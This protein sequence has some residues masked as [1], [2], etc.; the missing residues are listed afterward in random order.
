MSVFLVLSFVLCGCGPYIDYD[1]YGLGGADIALNLPFPSGQYWIMTQ[2]YKTGSH[3]DY[4]FQWGNDSFALDFAQSGC[5]AYGEPVTPVADGQVIDVKYEGNGDSGYGNTVLVRHEG[6]YVSRYAH[7]S[8]VYVEPGQ[9]LSNYDY[10]GAVGDTGYVS[11]SSCA[12]HPGTHLHLA[13]YENTEPRIPEPM[14]GVMPMETGCWYNREGKENCSGDPGDYEPLSYIDDEGNMTLDMLELRPSWGTASQTE[15]VWS[16][17]V[18]S[19]D[20]EPEVKLN[21]YN[22]NDNHTYDFNMESE[23]EES[24]WVFT[25]R[26]SLR[27]PARYSYW[28][29]TGNGDGNDRSNT[30]TVSVY[31]DVNDDPTVESMSYSP[32]S[33]ESRDT[34]FSW[35]AFVYSDDR[36]DMTLH[37]VNPNDGRIYEFD[38]DVDSYGSRW[39]GEYEK[40]LRDKTIYPFW[41]SVDNDNSTNTSY[42]YSIEVD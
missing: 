26:K 30:Y 16:T 12:E 33:G 8:E 41:V 40:H 1:K 5:G 17:V 4:G 22:P 19:P 27:D 24:P 3:K 37:I 25:Y 32:H 15:F 35:T 34:E 21:I 28:V 18:N 20:Y 7:L 13:F 14:S 11:G 9:S 29:T 42:V 6:N 10:L 36:P 31:D 2:G 38:M 23:S 39:R